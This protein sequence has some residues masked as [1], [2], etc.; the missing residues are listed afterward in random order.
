MLLLALGQG[1]WAR[2]RL[3]EH[4]HH[5][6]RGNLVKRY[7]RWWHFGLGDRGRGWVPC[8][9]YHD[10]PGLVVGA[11]RLLGRRLGGRLGR[12]LGGRRVAILGRELWLLSCRRCRQARVGSR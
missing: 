3:G 1:C 5:D 11:C 4:L 6:R 7:R 9:Y 8:M 12:R 2:G 10:V